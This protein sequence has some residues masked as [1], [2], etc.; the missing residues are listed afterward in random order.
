MA[1]DMEVSSIV[2]YIVLIGLGVLVGYNLRNSYAESKEQKT[3]GEVD[4]AIRRKLE[5]AENLNKSLLDDVT[6]LRKKID[7]LNSKS[8]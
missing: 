1:V 8:S 7:V 2:V 6:Y 3:I 5:I 4:E